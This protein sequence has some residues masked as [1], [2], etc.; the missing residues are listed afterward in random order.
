MWDTLSIWHDYTADFLATGDTL[1]RLQARENGVN[2]EKVMLP[3]GESRGREAT[4]YKKVRIV[5]NDGVI[6]IGYVCKERIN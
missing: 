2:S 4:W 5:R 3:W 1:G 6:T